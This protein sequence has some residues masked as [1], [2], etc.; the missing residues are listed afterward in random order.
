MRAKL[1]FVTLISKGLLILRATG[2]KPHSQL[3]SDGPN[4]PVFPVANMN[5]FVQPLILSM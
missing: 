3:A 2:G 4:L 1:A 5:S